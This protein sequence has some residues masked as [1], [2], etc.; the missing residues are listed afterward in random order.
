MHL[1]GNLLLDGTERKIVYEEVPEKSFYYL[2]IDN[3][4]KEFLKRYFLNIS[5]Y[6]G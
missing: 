5:I 6:T 1:S 3:L 2:L 4:T